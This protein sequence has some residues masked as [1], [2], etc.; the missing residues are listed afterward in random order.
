MRRKKKKIECV[1]DINSTYLLNKHSRLPCA[2]DSL[3]TPEQYHVVHDNVFMYNSSNDTFVHRI[4]AAFMVVT[5]FE[6]GDRYLI[7]R[8][9]YFDKL[10]KRCRIL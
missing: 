8:D 7:V 3:I 2:L 1:R 4:G 10:P 9:T 5:K 6:D